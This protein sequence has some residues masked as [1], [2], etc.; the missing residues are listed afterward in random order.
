MRANSYPLSTVFGQDVRYVV[1]LY[2]RPYVWGRDT[3]WEPLWDDVRAL[4]HRLAAHEVGGE[5]QEG[6]APHFLGA[7]VL[8]QELVDT[9]SLTTR[10]VIDGQQRLT[11]LQLLIAA[12]AYVANERGHARQAR[13]LRR[14][15]E[16][17]PDLVTEPSSAFKVW[18]TNANRSAFS[19]VMGPNGP[20]DRHKDDPG[21]LIDEAFAYFTGA[22]REWAEDEGEDGEDEAAIFDALTRA[23]RELI[24]IV[25]I[26][27]EEGDNAQVIFETLNA[28]GT[29]LLAVDLVKNLVFQ[30]A[31]REGADLDRLYEEQWAQFDGPTWRA[32]VRQGRLR[33]PR[34]EIFLMHWLTMKRADEVSA[35][36]LYPAFRL[37]LESH[38]S[39][40]VVG[41]IDDFARD[42]R[43]FESFDSRSDPRERRFFEHLALLDTSTVLPVV[44]FVMGLPEAALPPERRH[45]VLEI[46]ESYLVR[47]LLCQM[48]TKNYNRTA[49][50]ILRDVKAQPGRADEVLV[51]R[52]TRAE[53]LATKWPTDEDVHN[54]LTQRPVYGWIAQARVAMVLGQVERALRSDY[55]E[56]VALPDK[57]TIEHVMPQKW[58]PHWPL[59]PPGDAAQ[60][61]EREQRIH[62]IG[63]LTLVTSKLNPALSNSNW[64]TKRTALNQHSVLLL[65]R[66]LV[67]LHPDTWG[68]QEIDQR[69]Q[70]IADIVCR[71]WKRPEATT[72]GDPGS[73]A[74]VGEPAPSL[75]EGGRASTPAAH[76]GTRSAAAGALEVVTAPAPV[77]EAPER[78]GSTSGDRALQA[79]RIVRGFHEQGRSRA[80]LAGEFGMEPGEVERL[81]WEW[82]P[83]VYPHAR[84]AQTAD[85]IVA[86][87]E[88]HLSRARLVVEEAAA[89]R[90]DRIAARSGLT[91]PEV[92]AL[93]DS[94]QGAGAAANSYVGRGRDFRQ[95]PE[96]GEPPG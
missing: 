96:G 92:K 87:R 1:P 10:L 44:L 31:S 13:L 48:T 11:T 91:V 72:P 81:L 18:P 43:L 64:T 95:S 17:D 29:P 59:D 70:Q 93:Y 67:D 26:D 86:A 47:R 33:R 62:R 51:E 5:G 52:L 24:K 82:E 85:D 71:I 2:Q 16:N 58:Q 20:A 63:N 25:V 88:G 39:E 40:P 56:A 75:D 69:C 77:A 84:L 57:L 94:R 68:E 55:S 41:L 35:T 38:G 12:A 46:I 45:R 27:L 19:A 80:D 49:M 73:P 54:A 89:L 6:A 90:W 83:I 53:G 65:N 60:I 4:V 66:R 23:V 36:A 30:A 15:V 32:E 79:D 28:R 7:I 14:L 21:N 50:E 9:G 78:E 37:Y 34:A 22:V 61:Q 42:A 8:E 3:H 74:I 76:P